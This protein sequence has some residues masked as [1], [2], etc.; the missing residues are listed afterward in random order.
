MHLRGRSVKTE[1]YLI[2][3]YLYYTKKNKIKAGKHTEK[4]IKK[5]SAFDLYKIGTNSDFFLQEMKLCIMIKGRAVCRKKENARDPS[6]PDGKQGVN[7]EMNYEIILASGSPRRKEILSQIGASFRVVV[8]ECDE[9]TTVREPDLLVK[10][11]SARKAEAVAKKLDG[12]VI[13]LGADTVVAADG[14]ILGKPKNTED[15]HR[16]IAMLSGGKHQVYTGVCILIKEADGNTQKISFAEGSEVSVNPMTEQQIAAYVATSEP[17]DKAGGYAIQGL[18]AA[19]ISRIEG[20][21]YNIVGLPVAGI[22]RRL[23]QMGIDLKT[24]RKAE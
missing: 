7:K 10:E 19:Y 5:I 17:Y 8:S 14:Q 4:C 21:Y 22:Y 23:A 3:K 9:N 11:L 13:V 20:D 6:G 1:M 2:Y 12:P 24:G 18:F 16:M 15:A